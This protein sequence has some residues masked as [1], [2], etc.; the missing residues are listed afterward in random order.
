MDNKISSLETPNTPVIKVTDVSVVL[1]ENPVLFD[2]SMQLNPGET[3]ALMG[4]NGA[5]KTTLVRTILGLANKRSG[6]IELF[7]TPKH[8]FRSWHRIGYVPQ[9][10]AL[11]LDNATVAEVVSS[12]RLANRKWFFPLSREDKKAISEALEIVHLTDR[13]DRQ[14]R[15]LSGG[16]QQRALIAR[17]LASKPDLLILDE[18]LAGLDLK[19]QD[20]LAHLLAGFKAN[21]IS[22]L[23]IL[24]E[25]GPLQQMIDRSV[26]LQ[27][28]RVIYDGPL[29]EIQL[30]AQDH[31]AHDPLPSK[32]HGFRNNTNL[33]TRKAHR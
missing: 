15:L 7:G 2:V 12:G 26:V 31:H 30:S 18:P 25:M 28:G 9:R 3:L 27:T 4:G 10:G 32:T 13:K 20:E 14:L 5:G 29:Q 22:F 19:T 1:G 16:Q 23:M 24:H 8:K 6:Q 11:Q 17:A 33:A 21:G